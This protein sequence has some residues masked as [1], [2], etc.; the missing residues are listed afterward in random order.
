MALPLRRSQ[1]PPDEPD[2]DADGPRP[3]ARLLLA[4]VLVVATCGLIYEL[5]AATMPLSDAVASRSGGAGPR[6]HA[7]GDRAG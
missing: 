2:H 4:S 1:D 7:G 5:I 3:G 6:R